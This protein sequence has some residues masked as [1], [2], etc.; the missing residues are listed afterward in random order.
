[1]ISHHSQTDIGQV[2]DIKNLDHNFRRSYEELAYKLPAKTLKPTF[3]R[4]KLPSQTML[5]EE[6]PG[7]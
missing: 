6:T 3:S 2:K 1:M 4:S 5:T 7:S